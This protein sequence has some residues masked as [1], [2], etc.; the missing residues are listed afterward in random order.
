[1]MSV[2][3]CNRCLP[4]ED[5]GFPLSPTGSTGHRNDGGVWSAFRRCVPLGAAIGALVGG[6][7]GVLIGNP[8]AMLVGGSAGASLGSLRCNEG[9]SA[10]T[11]AFGRGDLCELCREPGDLETCSECGRQVCWN[12]RCLIMAEEERDGRSVYRHYVRQEDDLNTEWPY[13]RPRS[14]RPESD[15]AQ[16]EHGSYEL[17]EELF[18]LDEDGNLVSLDETGEAL[19]V[20][21][22]LSAG[23]QASDGG[24]IDGVSSWEPDWDWE[25]AT[26]WESSVG[27]FD[28]EGGSAESGAD[29]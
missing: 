8:V 10:D 7:L 29:L 4:Q 1:M 17:G 2:Y 9:A 15:E 13:W 22:E 6:L 14:A 24:D 11:S 27:D 25:P 26:S 5:S 23:Q 19:A 18:V 3:L 16:P 21:A 12:C 28:G 20:D